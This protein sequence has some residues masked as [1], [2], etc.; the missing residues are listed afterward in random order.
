MADKKETV[1]CTKCTFDNHPALKNCEMCTAPLRKP[2][3]KTIRFD[4]EAEQ[5]PSCKGAMTK[6]CSK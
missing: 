6:G 3:P 1:A 4:E 5:C 2:N